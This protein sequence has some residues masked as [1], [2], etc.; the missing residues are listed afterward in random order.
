MV[1]QSFAVACIV[2]FKPRC[3]TRTKTYWKLFSGSTR[4][5][6]F[7]DEDANTVCDTQTYCRGN[8]C[9][10]TTVSAS[11][12]K[13]TGTASKYYH[14]SYIAALYRNKICEMYGSQTYG[15]AR[16]YATLPAAVKPAR[17][18]QCRYL[19]GTKP[20]SFAADRPCCRSTLRC[21]RDKLRGNR[22]FRMCTA[23]LLLSDRL[24]PIQRYRPTAGIRVLRLARSETASLL[25]TVSQE[26]R[27]RSVRLWCVELV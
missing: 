14:I 21:Q 20:Y 24:R 27:S 15:Q 19:C 26:T 8:E 10:S 16:A 3:I 18:V 7:N 23:M 6:L 2:S 12:C 13:S 22:H 1:G 25:P 5:F 9:S 11:V 17:Q 4:H